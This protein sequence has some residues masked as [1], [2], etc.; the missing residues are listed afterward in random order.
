[1]TP[2]GLQMAD[3]TFILFFFI[4]ILAPLLLAWRLVNC[5]INWGH[6]HGVNMYPAKKRGGISDGGWYVDLGSLTDLTLM[7]CA[8]VPLDVMLE[9]WPPKPV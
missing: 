4:F 7:T 8:D 2:F 5:D 3:T 9:G 1:M 6:E